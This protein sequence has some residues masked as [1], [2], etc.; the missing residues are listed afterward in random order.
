MRADG[1]EFP[2]EI[3]V[4]RPRVAGPPLFTGFLRDVT[5]R[6]RDE[7]AL[8][9]LAEQQAALRRVATLV[10]SEAEQERVFG[11]VTREVG[12]LLEAAT[13][14]MVRYEPPTGPAWW[15]APG[16]RAACAQLPW[17]RAWR[18]TARRWPRGSVEPGSR[19]GSTATRVWPARPPSCFA[20]LASDRPSVRRIKLGGRLWGAVMV[21][22]VDEKPF[23]P[24]SEQRVADFSELVALALANAE[25][26]EELAASRA[27][28][29]A[30]GDR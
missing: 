5:R 12:R 9:S 23:P 19:N 21:S 18:S 30:A 14:N 6:K 24:G 20:A 13:C 8:R 11:V 4:T 15:R 16:A 25:A 17:R 27:R 1:S 7:Q 28:I 2:V 10:A 3:A 22:T 29:V 26:R